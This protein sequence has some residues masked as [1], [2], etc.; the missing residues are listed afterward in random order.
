MT[1]A[2]FFFIGYLLGWGNA[3]LAHFVVHY[4]DDRPDLGGFGGRK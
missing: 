1:V 4:K 3:V 2:T